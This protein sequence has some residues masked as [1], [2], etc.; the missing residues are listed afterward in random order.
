MNP[1]EGHKGDQRA[2]ASLL[3]GQDERVGVV[4]PGR[5]FGVT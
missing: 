5:G 2:E 4:Q 3:R 1:E